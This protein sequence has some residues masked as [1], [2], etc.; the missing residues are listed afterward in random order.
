[1]HTRQRTARPSVVR[2]QNKPHLGPDAQVDDKSM[3]FTPQDPALP[4]P[5]PEG[6]FR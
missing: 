4:P 6:V 1:M 3:W 5:F 2:V